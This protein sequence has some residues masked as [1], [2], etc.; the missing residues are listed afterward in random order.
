MTLMETVEA[1]FAEDEWPTT[2][3]EGETALRSRFSSEHGQWSCFTRVYET[4][5][6]VL[7]Y[8][9][10]PI[11]APEAKRL[12]IAE[13]LTRANYGLLIGNFELDFSDG[14]I[15][16]KTALDA[17][18]TTLT[19]LAIKNL[20]YANVLT[21]NRY[22]PAIMTVLYGDVAPAEAIAKVEAA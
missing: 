13:T 8:S 11:N 20:A 9:I 15:R 12:A 22:L 18:G 7:F 6:R 5:Q 14:E 4:E 21:M 2:P 16:Y 19:T 1:F 17:E 10:S 3:V